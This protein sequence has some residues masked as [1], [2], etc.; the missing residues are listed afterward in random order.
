[1]TVS[2]FTEVS[3]DP[4]LVLICIDKGANTQP[5][6]EQGRVF[7]VN[8]LARDQES[9][10]RRFARKQDEEQR[11]AGLACEAGETGAPLIAGCVASLD[12]TLA[13]SLEAGDHVIHVGRVVAV[14]VSDREPLMF[15]NRA[16]CS[17][18]D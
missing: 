3:L 6:I 15:H 8:I 18:G 17:L 12:C 9:L 1:M 2:A 4:P 13:E 10:A 7:A 5:V 14:R 16:Y 11:F